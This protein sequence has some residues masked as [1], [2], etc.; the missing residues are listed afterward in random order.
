MN[1]A[2]RVQRNI[3]YDK[4]MFV[5]DRSDQMV[6]PTNS[7]SFSAYQYVPRHF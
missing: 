3:A 1:T 6:L 5:V 4:R 2:Y 7:E